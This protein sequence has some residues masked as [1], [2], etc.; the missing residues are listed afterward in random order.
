MTGGFG[1]QSATLLTSTNLNL[2]QLR[3]PVVNH[4][5][6]V[7]LSQCVRRLFIQNE[8]NSSDTRYAG[9]SF[10]W[11]VGIAS[12]DGNNS[13]IPT[14]TT[15]YSPG[16]VTISMSHLRG[17]RTWMASVTNNRYIWQRDFVYVPAPDGKSSVSYT[18]I[19]VFW[20]QSNTTWTHDSGNTG[21]SSST[22]FTT[23]KF[24]GQDYTY[25]AY[26][27]TYGFSFGP[28]GPDCQPICRTY[29]P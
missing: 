3:G 7:S 20:N 15:N 27:Y 8:A 17:A 25:R 16:D 10:P 2:G 22:V 1:T 24:A 11:R 23:F 29:D 6:S 4:N 12:I 18:A 14:T 19:K 26:P 28:A 13:N 5:A 21:A 9:T